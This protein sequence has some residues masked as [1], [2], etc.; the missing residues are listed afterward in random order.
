MTINEAIAEARKMRPT[1]QDDETLAPML[2]V[3]DDEIAEAMGV[4]PQ[5]FLYPEID[6]ELLMPAPHDRIYPLYLVGQID[7]YNQEISLYA[8]DAETYN[9]AMAEAKAWYRRHNRPT[10]N[11]NWRI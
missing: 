4:S 5:D 7:Y 1:A 8:N 10:R 2:R 3:V 6:Y 11:V 9:N